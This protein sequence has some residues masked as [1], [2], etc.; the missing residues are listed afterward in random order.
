MAQA[1]A[2]RH[3]GRGRRI[4]NMLVGMMVKCLNLLRD[5]VALWLHG[6]RIA[7]L[8]YIDMGQVPDA[9]TT[10]LWVG[11]PADVA[12][13]RSSRQ[14]P[15]AVAALSSISYPIAGYL[16]TGSMQE[17]HWPC[18]ADLVPMTLV[19]RPSGGDVP[20]SLCKKARAVLSGGP[21]IVAVVDGVSRRC[22]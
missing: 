9:F 2:G 11:N 5:P 3:G 22:K 13:S 1:T 14:D 12:G 16:D 19:I 6:S 8:V 17:N 15:V 10:R 20:V 18:V 21:V 4:A 7:D